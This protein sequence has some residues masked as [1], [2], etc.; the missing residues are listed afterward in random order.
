[1]PPADRLVATAAEA[2]ACRD[3]HAAASIA[4]SPSANT[5]QPLIRSRQ[6]F[7]HCLQCKVAN[8]ALSLLAMQSGARHEQ[9][10]K[11]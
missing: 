10:E 5:L 4:C 9:F 3:M 1:M 7:I 11:I 8:P 6:S 2:E